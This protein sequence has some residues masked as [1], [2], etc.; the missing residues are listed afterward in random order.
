M[1]DFT[2]CVLIA[3]AMLAIAIIPALGEH[4]DAKMQE[5]FY[6]EMVHQYK[7]SNGEHGWPDYKG[8]FKRVCK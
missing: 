1:S 2:I 7:D 5:R 3:V 6:C 4:A 8:I